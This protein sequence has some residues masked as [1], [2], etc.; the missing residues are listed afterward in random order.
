MKWW[1]KLGISTRIFINLFLLLSMTFGIGLTAIW[2]AVQFNTMLNRVIAEDMTALQASR[3]IETELANQ[4]GFVTYYF[5]DGDPKWLNELAVHRRSFVNWLQQ[6]YDVDQN[7]EHRK[8]LDQIQE[9]YEKY[10]S[11]KDHVIELYQRGDRKAGEALH[12]KVRESFFELN[13]LC[14]R[15]M[16]DNES[17]IKE[18]QKAG[19]TRL[20]RISA[21][22]IIFMSAAL[23]L[24]GRCWF[25]SWSP[26]Y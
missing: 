14:L 8:L 6:A 25:F 26:R 5:L 3:E 15:Y 22:A 19:H 18:V 11:D 16:H 9:K 10:K 13:E 20:Q 2:Y 24:G 1:L 12:W 4:K 21:V 17:N 23:V 7:P